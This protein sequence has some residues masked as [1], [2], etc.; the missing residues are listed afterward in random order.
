MINVAGIAYSTGTTD[1]RPLGTKATVTCD[2][3]FGV[4]GSATSTCTGD[5]TSTTGMFDPVTFTCDREWPSDPFIYVGSA[6]LLA[7]LTVLC[8]PQSAAC[9]RRKQSD[10]AFSII[11]HQCSYSLWPTW[12]LAGNN[13]IQYGPPRKWVPI[14]NCGNLWLWCNACYC[15]RSSD[16]D[17]WRRW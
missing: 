5:G 1:I 17:L 15:G 11:F 3:G 7:S 13:D 16:Q 6:G 10:V 12:W 4:V 9:I 14:W 8:L 2:T